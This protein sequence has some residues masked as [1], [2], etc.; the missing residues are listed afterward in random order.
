M[1]IFGQT[2]VSVNE[3]TFRRRILDYRSLPH[4]RDGRRD[5]GKNDKADSCRTA[6]HRT[7]PGGSP[8][9]KT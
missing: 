1:L 5:D 3:L 2:D 7:S 6:G 8:A 4:R 9:T